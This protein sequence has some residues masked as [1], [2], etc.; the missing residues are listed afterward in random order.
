MRISQERNSASEDLHQIEIKDQR[1]DNET[2]NRTETCI[3]YEPYYFFTKKSLN[4]SKLKKENKYFKD[5]QNSKNTV[6][7]ILYENQ[8]GGSFCGTM[9]FSSNSLLFFD[10][11]PWTDKNF[12]SSLV[13]TSTAT[14]PGPSWRWTWDKWKIDMD[15]NVDAEGWSYS[16]SFWSKK[17]YGTCIWFHSFVRRRKW[18]R[19]RQWKCTDDPDIIDNDNYFTV[20]SSYKF[21]RS[22]TSTSSLNESIISTSKNLKTET[23]IQDLLKKLK[24]YRIDR[25]RLNVL[26]NFILSNNQNIILLNDSIKD[27][28]DC[29]IFQESRRQ[30][31]TF[32]IKIIKN[33]QTQ[34]Q[35]ISNDLQKTINFIKKEKYKYDFWE[36]KQETEKSEITSF[37]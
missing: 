7:D 9:M 2:E 13:N 5:E 20:N 18:I 35:S 26:E 11:S 21:A 15:G 22:P 28:L 6:I 33:I 31:L 23:D 30:F 19:E 17:W 1:N 8:R 34:N 4:R 14:C 29:F 16:F 12:R 27:I 10:P 3:E 37:I 32:L 24:E 36:D 25:E